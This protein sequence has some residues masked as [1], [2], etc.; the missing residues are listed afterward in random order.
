M[1]PQ[2]SRRLERVS[3]HLLSQSPVAEV[4]HGRLKLI[5]VRHAESAENVKM[6]GTI[7]DR[8]DGKTT[9]D[10]WL[11]NFKAAEMQ[12]PVPLSDLGLKQADALGTFWSKSPELVDAPNLRM[13]VSPYLRCCQT[14][15][16]D[17]HI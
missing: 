3:A 10:E 11:A 7:I 6:A 12:D 13:F 2:Q 15:V 4:R 14:A 9:E 17:K 1:I 16:G 8:L 5:M